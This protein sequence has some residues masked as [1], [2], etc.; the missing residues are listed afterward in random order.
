MA[1]FEVDLP[2]GSKWIGSAAN[3]AAAIRAALEKRYGLTGVPDPLTV[4]VTENT[5]GAMLLPEKDAEE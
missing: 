5:G 4:T 1:Q 2:D 3:K